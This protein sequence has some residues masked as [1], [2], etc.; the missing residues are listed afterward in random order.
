MKVDNLH[1][2]D[3]SIAQALELQWG[4]ASQIS[5]SG[6]V[7][8]PHFIAGVDVSVG[9][10]GGMATAA[11]VVLNYPELKVVET[12]VVKRKLDFPYVPGLLSFRELPI[13]LAACQ[14]LIV[15]P[16]LI[17]V[18][19]QGIAHPRRIGL[20]SHLGLFLDVPTIGCAK[21]RLCGIHEVP[22]TEPGSYAEVVDGTETIGVALR[23]KLKVKPI[24]V[25]IG[26][27][28]D[29]QSAISWVMNCCCGYRLPEPTRFAHQAAAGSLV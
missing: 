18:D 7:V 24:Y 6:E 9:K 20:A 25:S 1:S 3:V 14:R 27:K 4:L 22:S 21:S 13:T 28:V 8:A 12:Q 17:L 5:R 26:H 10:A 2:W 29:L 15:T 16:A 19:G 11:V 23:T